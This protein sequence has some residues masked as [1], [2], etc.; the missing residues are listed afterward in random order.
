MRIATW[1]VNWAGPRSPRYGRI[2]LRLDDANADVLVITEGQRG[3]LPAGESIDAGS[4]WGYG[5]KP[6]RRKVLAWSKR[7]WRE[8]RRLETGAARGRVLA[9]ITD[10]EDGPMAVIAVCVPWKD[11]HV[12]SGRGGGGRAGAKPWG[13]HIECC[14]Q[15]RKF[16]AT[17]AANIPTLIV[18][19]YNQRIPRHG[20]SKAAETALHEALSGMSVWTAGDTRCGKLIDHVAGSPDLI[21]HSIE[22][23]GATD[24]HGRLSDH[25][26][27]VCSARRA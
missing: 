25:A 19:D 23:W 1:N 17:V 27:V 16:R 7:P 10:T 8:V 6:D 9:A 13:E 24:T 20:Q 2:S 5:E 4:D 14:E 12:R 18:G 26:G 11:A 22:V 21:A 3:L 15:L